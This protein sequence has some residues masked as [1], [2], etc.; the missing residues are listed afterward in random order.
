MAETGTCSNC[1]GT[2]YVKELKQS[3]NTKYLGHVNNV[4]QL[5]FQ[6]TTYYVNVPCPVCNQEE[7]A[8]LKKVEDE[9]AEAVGYLVVGLFIAL[10]IIVAVMYFIT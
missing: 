7:I 3:S 1:Q 5:E 6:T 10:L 2:R 9:E 4:P 8:R